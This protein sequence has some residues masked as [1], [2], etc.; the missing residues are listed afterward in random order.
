MNRMEFLKTSCK[1]G[2]CS[3]LGVA[4]VSP[5]KL[6]AEEENPELKK[7]RGKLDFI[8]KLFARLI[9]LMG[10]NLDEK[11]KIK[12]LESLGMECAKEYNSD[13]AKY[14]NNLEGFLGEVKKKWVDKVIQ[15][16]DKKTIT[17]IGKKTGGCFCPFV[18]QSITP[19]DFCNCSVG[20]QKQAFE[21]VTGKKVVAKVKESILRGG[22]RCSFVIK[23]A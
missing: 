3:C 12:M 15:D 5:N 14:K 22:E 7:L 17:L 19:A 2:I 8:H 10:S 1:L 4:M 9:N 11:T 16:K 21:T 18:K 6:L 20:W 13:F 23:L